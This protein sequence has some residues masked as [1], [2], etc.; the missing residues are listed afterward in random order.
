MIFTPVQNYD[1][2]VFKVQRTAY[3]VITHARNWSI[4]DLCKTIIPPAIDGNPIVLSA[5]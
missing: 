1:T 4:L 3:D 5:N 2:L